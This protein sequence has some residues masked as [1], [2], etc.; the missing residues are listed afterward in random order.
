MTTRPIGSTNGAWVLSTVRGED[1]RTQAACRTEN[2]QLW[3]AT[4]DGESTE[5]RAV[6]HK[7]A[8]VI[9]EQQCTVGAQ[10]L[11]SF[12]R[13]ADEGIRAGRELPPIIPPTRAT[14][15]EIN[16]GTERGAMQ[17]R[18][19]KEQACQS[20]RDAVRRAK[21][22]RELKRTDAPIVHG[23][24]YGARQHQARGERPCDDCREFRNAHDRARAARKRMSRADQAS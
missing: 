19:R 20:C 12:V 3:D 22:D 15:A 21:R 7:Q 10:C 17:H 16:H 11:S 24:L 13:G 4:I 1:W 18:R 9:C 5:D 14:P 6:R 8:K 23:T 2:P